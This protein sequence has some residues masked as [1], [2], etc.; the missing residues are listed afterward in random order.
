MFRRNDR[1]CP[2][3]K[4]FELIGMFDVLEHVQEERETLDSLLRLLTPGGRLLLTVPAHKFLWSYFDEAAHHCRRYSSKELHNKLKA[5]GFEVEYQSQFMTCILPLVWM[6]R[7]IGGRQQVAQS[8]DA[9]ALASKEF[10]LVPIINGILMALLSP[11]AR[12]LAR[13]HSLPIGTSLVVIARK[14]K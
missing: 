9:K 7:K 13:G 4:Q 1:N 8:R 14:P 10:R 2:F 12:W 5:A 6:F 11:E 3:G